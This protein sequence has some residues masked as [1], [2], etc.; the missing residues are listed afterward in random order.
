MK[1]AL[2]V[3]VCSSFILTPL[4]SLFLSLGVALSHCGQRRAHGQHEFTN[5]LAQR[6]RVQRELCA[7]AALAPRI[8]AVPSHGRRCALAGAHSKT[9]Y[10]LIKSATHPNV[11]SF[12]NLFLFSSHIVFSLHKNCILT[13]VRKYR[14]SFSSFYFECLIFFCTLFTC[15]GSGVEEIVWPKRNASPHARL[16]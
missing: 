12:L 9:F 2:F 4:N 13:M 14:N 7:C 16:G 15:K 3:F 11:C 8:C 5:A 1:C 10:C 6:P